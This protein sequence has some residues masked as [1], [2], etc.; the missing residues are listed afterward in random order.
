MPRKSQPPQDG[1]TVADFEASMQALEAL[2]ARMETGGM[3]LEE[4]LAAYEQGVGLYRR[5]QSALEQAELRVRMLG[6][7]NAP[8]AGSDFDPARNDG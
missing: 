5:C 2:V 3:S 1:S 7:P 6:D 8:E 4:S